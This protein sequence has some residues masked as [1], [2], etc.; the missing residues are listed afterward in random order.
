MI[1][2]ELQCDASHRFEG[3]FGSS[4]AFE[5]Q[6]ESGDLT[7]PVCGTTSLRRIPS[8]AHVSSGGATVRREVVSQEQSAARATLEKLVEFVRG[9]YDDVGSRFP[10]EARRIHY[11][12][13]DARNIRGIATARD[14]AELV[15]EGVAVAPLPGIDIEKLN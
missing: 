4:R 3:W 6:L 10:E 14:F 8:A 1:V 5:N 7:C 2:Y 9:N 12:E 13:A 11:G 15:D